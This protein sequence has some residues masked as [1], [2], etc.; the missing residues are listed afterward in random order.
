[1]VCSC[2][3]LTRTFMKCRGLWCR[4]LQPA[5]ELRTRFLNI[6]DG[7]VDTL[8]KHEKSNLQVKL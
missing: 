1:M 6:M 2:L 4:G 3:S 8:F 7:A 5:V